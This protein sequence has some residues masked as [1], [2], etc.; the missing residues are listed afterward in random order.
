MTLQQAF[1]DFFDNRLYE[2]IQLNMRENYY[3]ELLA[4][5]EKNLT[6]EQKILLYDV[7]DEKNKLSFLQAEKAYKLGGHDF[8]FLICV[9]V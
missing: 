9:H 3:K 4:K 6:E 5:L 1:S 7:I 2:E 8:F